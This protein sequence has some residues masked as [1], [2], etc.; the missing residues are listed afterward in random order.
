MDLSGLSIYGV[1][2]LF[3]GAFLDLKLAVML[4]RVFKLRMVLYLV[5]LAAGIT[6]VTGLLFGLWRT[7]I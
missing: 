2:Y 7:G 6:L 1:V 5:S 4:L 3:A